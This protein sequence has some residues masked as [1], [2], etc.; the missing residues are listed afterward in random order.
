MSNSMSDQISKLSD[1]DQERFHE[2]AQRHLRRQWAVARNQTEKEID[3]A[4][5]RCTQIT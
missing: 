5:K 4:V 1:E 3:D 2:E